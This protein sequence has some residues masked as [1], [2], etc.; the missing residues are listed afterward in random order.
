MPHPVL[1]DI[2]KQTSKHHSFSQRT[3]NRTS[4][5]CFLG[6]YN[7]TSQG[8]NSTSPLDELRTYLKFFS[9]LVEV[10]YFVSVCFLYYFLEGFLKSNLTLKK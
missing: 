9:F 6:E 10:G 3:R 8:V 1:L 5:N 4:L 7:G 2:E